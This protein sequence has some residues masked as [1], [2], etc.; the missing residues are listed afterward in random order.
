MLFPSKRELSCDAHMACNQHDHNYTPPGSLSKCLE[1]EITH[2]RPTLLLEYRGKVGTSQKGKRN[3]WVLPLLIH[4]LWTPKPKFTME[5]K[6]QIS[7]NTSYYLPNPQG[8]TS[9]ALN[10]LIPTSKEQT[11]SGQ[12]IKLEPQLSRWVTSGRK[13]NLT[14]ALFPH[15]ESRGGSPSIKLAWMENN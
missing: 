11:T 15:Q 6:S 5:I 12:S 8:I 3:D 1:L 14:V 2:S 7:N 13:L 10:F 4:W 9:L